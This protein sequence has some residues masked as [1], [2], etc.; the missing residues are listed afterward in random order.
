M[1]KITFPLNLQV[2]GP[3]VADLH[4]ALALLGFA[5]AKSEQTK[6]RFGPTTQA[7]LSKFQTVQKLAAT[8]EVD[9]ATADA[10]N[11]VLADMGAFDPAPGGG[12]DPPVPNIPPETSRLFSVQGEVVKPDGAP[13]PNQIVRAYDRALC[14]W[15]QLGDADAVV[16]TNDLGRYEFTYDPAQLTQWGRLAP[17]SRSRCAIRPPTPCSPSRR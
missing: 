10:L 14:E 1:N 3:E 9:A 15:R 17:T 7:A 4:E 13:V 8:G 5:I 2:Q 16:R 12:N 11:A 6:Q